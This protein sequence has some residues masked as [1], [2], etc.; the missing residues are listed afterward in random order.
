MAKSSR[1]R[2]LLTLTLLAA[3]LLGGSWSW[4]VVASHLDELQS[5]IAFLESELENNRRLSEESKTKE[6]KYRQ[7]MS[8]VNLGQD[9]MIVVQDQIANLVRQ[10]GVKYKSVRSVGASARRDERFE[11][12]TFKVEEMEATLEQLLHFLWLLDT[13]STVLEVN[14]MN[15]RANERDYRA[16]LRVDLEITRLSM[17][18]SAQ[19]RRPR[20]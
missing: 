1:E 15:I 18:E 10:S 11:S 20:P 17:L 8:E 3:L 16:P 12:I 7:V 9:K 14:N 13:S 6:E 4:R 19:G 5:Q 2:M